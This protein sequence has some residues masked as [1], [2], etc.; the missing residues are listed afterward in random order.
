MAG[1]SRLEQIRA[2]MAGGPAAVGSGAGA[3]AVESGQAA[4]AL[5]QGAP[6]VQQPAAEPVSQP[7]ERPDTVS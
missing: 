7:A 3:P 6:S 5:E 4:G 1:A 2:S